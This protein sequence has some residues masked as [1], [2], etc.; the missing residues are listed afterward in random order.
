MFKTKRE[1]SNANL[2]AV[3]PTDR[4]FTS[5]QKMSV[6]AT[7]E[8]KIRNMRGQVFTL[9]EIPTMTSN[10]IAKPLTPHELK[11]FQVSCGLKK[12]IAGKK[13]SLGLYRTIY[14]KRSYRSDN[15]QLELAF[16]TLKEEGFL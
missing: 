7:L 1:K 8:M 2:T 4:Y 14:N 6:A 9:K 5:C 13:G 12:A 3:S 10:T 16:K 15:A 11:V